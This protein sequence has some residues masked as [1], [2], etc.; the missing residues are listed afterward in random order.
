[1]KNHIKINILKSFL[2]ISI[3]LL[4]I[5][6]NIGCSTYNSKS[7]KQSK[8]SAQSVVTEK[9]WYT[10]EVYEGRN[11]KK[12]ST[13]KI[14]SNT[15]RVN[16]STQPS[17]KNPMAFQLYIFN[18]TGKAV[19]PGVIANIVGKGSGTSNISK[20]GDYYLYIVTAQKYKVTVEEL[21]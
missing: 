16:W 15:W 4:F 9:A 3:L 17:T 10:I 12:T 5:L 1:M 6:S 21:K 13:F 8:G 20:S 18:S 7:N 14:S 19:A 11:P 2:F